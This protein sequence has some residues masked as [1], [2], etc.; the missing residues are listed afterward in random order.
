MFASTL[1]RGVNPTARPSHCKKR[2]SVTFRT[3]TLL[4]GWARPRNT[5]RT[6]DRPRR[7]NRGNQLTREKRKR[8]MSGEREATE[9]EGDDQPGSRAADVSGLPLSIEKSDPSNFDRC[10]DPMGLC[11]KKSQNAA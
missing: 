7:G 1:I 6:Y 8:G 9:I 5:R 4:R 11:K 2:D 3:D 10:I